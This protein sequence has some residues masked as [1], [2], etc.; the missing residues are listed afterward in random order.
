M[1]RR[2]AALAA[3]AL[4]SATLYSGTSSAA[5]PC[6]DLQTPLAQ[7]LVNS[8]AVKRLQHLC[9]PPDVNDPYGC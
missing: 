8:S 1:T 6:N 4:A 7:C 3:A 2:L 9:F 5:L